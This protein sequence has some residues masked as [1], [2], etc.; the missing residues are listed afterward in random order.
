MTL[1]PISIRA[2][3]FLCILALLA[4]AACSSA[5]RQQPESTT[6][7]VKDG[8]T[9]PEQTDDPAVIT[10]GLGSEGDI[11]G[12]AIDNENP[13]DLA[14]R[15]D[16][17]PADVAITL[18]L[19][20]IEGFLGLQDYTSAEAQ[21]NY[22][23][24]VYLNPLQSLRFNL[25]RGR[26]AQ[27]LEQFQVAIAYLQ[28][29]RN[30]PLMDDASRAVVLEVLA[31]AQ[32]SLNRKIDALISLFARDPLL[33]AD[34]QL[35][36]QR[37]VINLIRSLNSQELILLRQTAANNALPTNLVDGWVA[38]TAVG[39]LPDIDQ[40]NQLFAWKNS[41]PNHPARDELLG[42]NATLTLDRF[43]HIALL[44]PLT[45]NFGN[46]AQAFYDGFLDAHDQDT[47][48]YKPSIS[49]HDIGEDPEL[50]S[51][52][53]QSVITEGADFVV[54][55]LGRDAV[56]TLLEQSTPQLP[57]LVIG[58]VNPLNASPNLYGMSLSPEQEAQQ[59]AQKAFADGHRQA[60]IFRSD[61]P[62]GERAAAAFSETWQQLGGT[63]VTD[64]SFPDSIEDYSRVIQRLLG[65]N[66]SVARERVLSAQLGLN[67]SFT[68]RRRDD[69]DLLFFA[70]NARQARLLI[71]QLRFFQAHNL[72]VYATSNIFTG[73]V[74]P[75]VD[76]DLDKVVF[77]DMRW[78]ID[79]RYDLP[80]NTEL[81][82]PAATENTEDVAQTDGEV[83]PQQDSNN[84]GDQ[85]EPEP[86]PVARSA[87]SFSP[88][89]RLYALGLE[90]YHLIPRLS[91]LRQDSWQQYNGQAFRASIEPS[92][93]VLRHLDWATFDKGYVTPAKQLP[94]GSPANI[95]QTPVPQ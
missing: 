90:S 14:L 35:T 23:V 58:D 86:E 70:G 38:F 22:L 67:L 9:G 40:Q 43:N 73:N 29:L 57:T 37:P 84:T 21:A 39:A 5:P 80:E 65:V 55:P 52:Y 69:L 78:M 64:K 28:P 8:I 74:N 88:L 7:S 53:Y 46:A 95:R 31:N 18:R 82:T 45:S 71:P 54:G 89:D 51:F 91:A 20:A 26:T 17:A 4:L 32:I 72:P 83:Q 85:P 68:P 63:I 33:P 44:L 62:W 6:I 47:S 81:L 24:D 76:A 30:D 66:Q 10:Q 36:N 3:R 2:S 15:A 94:L 79:I 1:Q 34:L 27:G 87:Y 92:G 49:L 42:S 60:G 61:S 25:L 50:V 56:N 16:Q 13:W 77:G 41:F 11:L 93:N 75:A 48:V 59:V 19:A 12:Q